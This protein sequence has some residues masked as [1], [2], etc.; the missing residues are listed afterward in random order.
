MRVGA[1]AE[2]HSAVGELIQAWGS[3]W[4]T[5]GGERERMKLN[6]RKKILKL[7]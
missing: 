6:Q 2:G 4:V 7:L 1:G 5:A 3:G